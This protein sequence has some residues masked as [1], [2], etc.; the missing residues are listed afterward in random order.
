MVIFVKVPYGLEPPAVL[1]NNVQ[2]FMVQTQISPE[3][4]CSAGR[5][6]AVGG[7]DGADAL[8]LS[9]CYTDGL[10]AAKLWKIC[11]F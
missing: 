1:R 6:L 10:H 7:D 8:G 3:K 9:T 5:V 11:A 2:R 4:G